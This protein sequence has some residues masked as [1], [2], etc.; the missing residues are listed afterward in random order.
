MTNS[1]NRKTS[2]E[3]V[4]QDLASDLNRIF[5]KKYIKNSLIT[6]I[7]GPA[8]LVRYNREE[9]FDCFI[10]VAVCFFLMLYGFEHI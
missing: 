5:T 2:I 9:F 10:V 6:N 7:M 1:K 8:I 3:G 4:W